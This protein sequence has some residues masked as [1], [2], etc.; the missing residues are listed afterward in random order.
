MIRFRYLTILL[1]AVTISQAN[2]SWRAFKEVAVRSADMM[3]RVSVLNNFMCGQHAVGLRNGPDNLPM[4]QKLDLEGL[5]NNNDRL[6]IVR[7]SIADL[8]GTVAPI[9]N[10]IAEYAEW[11]KNSRDNQWSFPYWLFPYRNLVK[12]A[13]ALSVIEEQGA[14]YEAGAE[15]PVVTY[16]WNIDSTGATDGTESG[17][18][19]IAI[20]MHPSEFDD[21][22]SR[23]EF[24][25]RF[26]SQQRIPSNVIF[27]TA[28]RK[29]CENVFGEWL[30]D[31]KDGDWAQV[32]FYRFGNEWWTSS[33][34]KESDEKNP[35]LDILLPSLMNDFLQT[36]R[37]S[38]AHVYSNFGERGSGHSSVFNDKMVKRELRMLQREEGFL[39]EQRAWVAINDL[40]SNSNQP[41]IKLRLL[42]LESS[43][44]SVWK[45]DVP[46]ALQKKQ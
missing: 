35:D 6:V 41:L 3:P 34:F 10:M 42:N 37:Y 1:A 27:F 16:K 2:A 26:L 7:P 21:F 9:V 5:K 4:L 25:K 43:L 36:G 22:L 45:N 18:R 30:V 24:W 19:T 12:A 28:P 44:T 15:L 11:T 31:T 13:G 46:S 39:E 20:Y 23:L 33:K 40:M 29:L 14:Y 32:R 17:K 38:T 8:S